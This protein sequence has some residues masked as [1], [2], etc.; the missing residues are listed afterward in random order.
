MEWFQTVGF[1]QVLFLA[2]AETHTRMCSIW[3]RPDRGSQSQIRAE[4]IRSLVIAELSFTWVQL[5]QLF[6]T[7]PWKK[8]EENVM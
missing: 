3:A 7:L 5:L 8:L 6:G 4:Q 1:D 2:P